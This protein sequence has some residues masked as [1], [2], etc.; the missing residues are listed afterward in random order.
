M[1]KLF[2]TSLFLFLIFT[3]SIY[4]QERIVEVYTS[5]KDASFIPLVDNKPL[6]NIPVDTF[7]YKVETDSIVNLSIDF[8]NKRIMDLFIAID[9]EGIKHQK[10][11]IVYKNK[12]QKTIDL[13]TDTPKND[14]LFDLFSLKNESFKNYLKNFND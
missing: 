13:L 5:I 1:K 4:A 12:A 6:S 2:T 8:T 7:L 9:F 14:T 10:Y 3:S 11:Q